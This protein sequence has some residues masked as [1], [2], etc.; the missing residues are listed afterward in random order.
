[1]ILLVTL[2]ISEGLAANSDLESIVTI[3]TGL[4]VSLI[5][6]STIVELGGLMVTIVGYVSFF[7][8]RVKCTSLIDY[9]V[10]VFKISF[11]LY[12]HMCK[13]ECSVIVQYTTVYEQKILAELIFKLML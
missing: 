1:M 13:G 3:F 11:R 5:T 6:T 4:D 12:V 9:C 2:A 10:L 8:V 7:F